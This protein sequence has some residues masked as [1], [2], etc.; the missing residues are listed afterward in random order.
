MFPGKDELSFIPFLR[1]ME[2]IF[3]GD[4]EDAGIHRISVNNLSYDEMMILAEQWK[5]FSPEQLL[6][7]TRRIMRNR[8]V[9]SKR[10]QIIIHFA[11][12]WLW[13]LFLEYLNP[14]SSRAPSAARTSLRDGN[15]KNVNR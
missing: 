8:E 6:A 10:R 9:K 13:W 5:A 4:I 15:I 2:T 14:I 12:N 3:L 11:V 1:S 7:W